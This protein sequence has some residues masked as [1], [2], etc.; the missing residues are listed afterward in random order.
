MDD[1]GQNIRLLFECSK[2]TSANANS[3]L[4]KAF[5]KGEW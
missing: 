5:S 3:C 1:G 2:K 4:T